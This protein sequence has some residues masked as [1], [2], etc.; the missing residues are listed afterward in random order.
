MLSHSP[1]RIVSDSGLLVYCGLLIYLHWQW[2][3][4]MAGCVHYPAAS[5]H[6]SPGRNAAHGPLE[7]QPNGAHALFT[8]QAM[9]QAPGPQI[10]GSVVASASL[11]ACERHCRCRHPRP[12]PPFRSCRRRS[13]LAAP[14]AAARRRL[15]QAAEAFE[16]RGC[17][18]D[19]LLRGVHPLLARDDVVGGV[20]GDRLGHGRLSPK[21]SRPWRGAPVGERASADAQR[22]YGAASGRV[23]PR[24]HIPRRAPFRD[25]G[26]QAPFG[27]SGPPNPKPRA[28]SREG[29]A[30]GSQEDIVARGP[31]V[32][33]QRAAGDPRLPPA[34]R[35]LWGAPPC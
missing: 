16:V 4:Y 31:L 34:V 15:C 8:K 1:T 5:S 12:L 11:P 13:P 19:H 28:Q 3:R 10:R 24:V 14:C 30:S 32:S 29:P 23:Q 6:P 22:R 18:L 27:G 21:D 7:M 17:G 33:T 35:G 9:S 2:A 26:P 25:S 20:R